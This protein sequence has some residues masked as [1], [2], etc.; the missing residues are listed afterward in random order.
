MHAVPEINFVVILGIGW[1][2]LH[3]LV[4]STSQSH[5]ALRSGPMVHA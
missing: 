2:T 4:V 3:L 1:Y 5:I